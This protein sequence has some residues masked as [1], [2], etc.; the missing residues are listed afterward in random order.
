MK[1]GPL[2]G[3]KVL[4]MSGIGP[5]PFAGML[6]ADMGADVVRVD[7]SRTE[8]EPIERDVISRG[9]RSIV[10]DLKQP[11]AV[12]AALLL[13]RSADVLIEGYRPGV[14]ERLGLGPEPVRAQNPALVYGRLTGWGQ[15]GPLAQRAGHDIN[16]L[17]L[18]GALHAI[19]WRDRPPSVPLNLIADYAGGSMF[20]VTGVLA[21]L[22]E[23]KRSGEGQVV[24]AAMLDGAT[25]LTAMFHGWMARG[26]WKDEREANLLDGGSYFYRAY[27]TK[28]GQSISVGPLESKFFQVLREKL[29]MSAAELPQSEPARWPELTVK[30][31]QVFR[32]KTRAE[33]A[34]LFETTDACV[35]PVLSMREAPLHPHNRARQLFESQFGVTQPAPAPRF[36]RTPSSI[37]PPPASVGEHTA[38]VLHDWGIEPSFVS[39]LLAAGVAG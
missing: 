27:E 32:T 1:T 21:A 37:T 8:S 18:S 24:D 10:L 13:C 36:D 7:R 23:A 4:E 22:H 11:K 5:C 15:S 35:G 3:L 34:E 25:L 31:E 20:L 6:F 17:G 16:Y 2:R 12:E 38:Q 39:A 30:L 19:G 28:D 14:M 33:W 9:K 29:G 26:L